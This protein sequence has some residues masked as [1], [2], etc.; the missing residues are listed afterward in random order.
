M[1]M[2]QHNGTLRGKI[3]AAD[4]RPRH[5][6]ETPEWSEAGVDHVWWRVPTLH[7]SDSLGASITDEKRNKTNL[8]DFRA[9]YLVMGLEDDS[10]NRIFRDEDASALAEKS[11]VVL[12]RLFT[13][14]QKFG[15]INEE[16]LEELKKSS[17]TTE[18]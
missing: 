9:K 12:S 13:E 7:Q 3:L 1:I 15:A 18:S 4:D 14:C 16:N 8:V 17:S 11:T 2:S 10:G 5:R 6:I